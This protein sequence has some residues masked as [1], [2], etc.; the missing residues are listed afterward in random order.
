VNRSL[1]KA[2]LVLT[3]PLRLTAHLT[4]S[5]SRGDHWRA[6]PNGRR[7]GDHL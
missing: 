5:G 4:D 2:L 3:Y 1:A 7:A 6:T